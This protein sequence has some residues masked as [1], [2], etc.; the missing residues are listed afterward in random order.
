MGNRLSHNICIYTA[1][2]VY[3]QPVCVENRVYEALHAGFTK[4]GYEKVNWQLGYELRFTKQNLGYE[5]I[6]R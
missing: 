1:V 2:P 3:E 5:K 6:V 4:I